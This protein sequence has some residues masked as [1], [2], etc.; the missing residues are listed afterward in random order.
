MSSEG[1]GKGR[2][3]KVQK[4][5][6]TKHKQTDFEFVPLD[7]EKAPRG[8]AR[9]R[10]PDNPFNTWV[11]QGKRPDWLRRYLEAGRKLSEFEVSSED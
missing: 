4:E 6:S 10:D 7:A 1:S 8:R 11:G 2:P 5:T 3:P 9:Y